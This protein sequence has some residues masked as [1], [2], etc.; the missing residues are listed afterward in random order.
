MRRCPAHPEE[1]IKAALEEGIK[2]HMLTNPVGIVGNGKVT[3]VECLRYE[4]GQFDSSRHRRPI[5]IRN[6]IL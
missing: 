2:L 6:L 4:L 5:P 1:E 3:G